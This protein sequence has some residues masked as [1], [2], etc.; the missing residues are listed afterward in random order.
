MNEAK[1]RPIEPVSVSDT[2]PALQTSP[3]RRQRWRKRVTT[4]VL[5]AEV[6]LAAPKLAHGQFLNV[7]DAIFISIQDDMGGS[8]D[9]INQIQQGVQQLYQT[10]VWP[11]AAINQARGF[12]SNSINTYRN[13]MSQMFNTHI[14]SATLAGPQQFENLLHS[15]LSSHIPSLQTSFTANYGPV[16]ALNKASPQDRVM[17]DID[18][19]LG[20]AAARLRSFTVA[21][22]D[23]L[24]VSLR[25]RTGR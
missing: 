25:V 10:T 23:G 4:A 1:H 5:I 7:F 15:R 18:D 17:M 14:S 22:G 13:A 21:S 24:A 3:S 11:L 20:Q 19:A 9:Q 16:P 2:S 6:C 12:V 8:L